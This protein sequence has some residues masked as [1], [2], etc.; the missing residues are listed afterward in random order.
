[1]NKLR[2]LFVFILTLFAF[3][4]L[5][6]NS[7]DPTARSVESKKYFAPKRAKATK[8]K[9]RNV[10][11]SAQYEFYRRVEMA[12]KDKQRILKKLSKPQF[13]DPSYFGHKRKPKR[14]VPHKMKFCHE[15]HIRH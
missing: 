7:V 12:A 2:L 6:Q 3:A 14:R 9:K 10:K 4:C 11:N 13:S 15:C 5:A 1:M 8:S